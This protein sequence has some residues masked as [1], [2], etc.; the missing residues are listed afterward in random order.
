MRKGGNV[1]PWSCNGGSKMWRSIIIYNGERL[2]VKDDW[3]IV[4]YEEGETKQI[5]M[6]DL[7]CI[8][9]DNRNLT[10]TVPVITSLA[11]HKVHVILTDE[12]HLPSAQIYP[13]NTNYHCFRILK[14]QLAMT[15][16]FRGI[17]WQRITQAK[18][19][20]QAICLENQWVEQDVIERMKE[21]AAEVEPH[22]EGKREG[23]SAKMFFRNAYGSEFVRF[24]DD[25]INAMLNYGYAIMRSAVAKALV[26]HGFN[27]VLGVHHISETNEFNLA[28]DFMEPLRALVDDW[29]ASHDSCHEEGLSKYVK[30]E[31]VNL[32]NQPIMFDGKEMK[33]RYAIDAMIRSFVTAVET[34]NP[35]R[36]I[37]PEVIYHHA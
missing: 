34:N 4:S 11:N 19:M 3:L 9:I 14:K 37:L 28:D 27:C 5:P 30:G 20:N 15:E 26:A 8:V 35:E 10:L 13:L 32:Y 29:V 24:A 36:L 21:L 6:E 17:I 31:L 23:I 18:I 2:S 16:E 22:D 25:N 1:N 7:Y 12:H 33:V